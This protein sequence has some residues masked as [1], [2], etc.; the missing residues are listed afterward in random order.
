MSL[1]KGSLQIHCTRGANGFHCWQPLW[2]WGERVCLLWH[3]SLAEQPWR[4]QYLVVYSVY[5]FSSSSP[6]ECEFLPRNPSAKATAGQ[7]KRVPAC[8]LELDW[9]QGLVGCPSCV[10]CLWEPAFFCSVYLGMEEENKVGAIC[11]AKCSTFLAL[12]NAVRQWLSSC[13]SLF[14]RRGSWGIWGNELAWG[15]SARKWQSSRELPVPF[16]LLSHFFGQF[17]VSQG[18]RNTAEGAIF[19]D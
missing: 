16:P 13:E 17:L 18:P 19:R 10:S 2:P 1:G 9:W 11:W 15:P 8:G 3:C 6:R 4:N 12:L 14:S 7:R 5:G